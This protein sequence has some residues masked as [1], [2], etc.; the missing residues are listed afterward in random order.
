MFWRKGKQTITPIKVDK[1][2]RKEILLA[3]LYLFSEH[4]KEEKIH[5]YK[6]VECISEVQKDLLPLGYEFSEKFLYS[7]DLFAD[8]DALRYEGY[9]RQYKSR[10]SDILPKNFVVLKPLGRVKA[11]KIIENLSPEI[12]EG[13]NRAITITLNRD[14]VLR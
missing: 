2:R 11:K 6:F 10:Q 5:R 1:S 14:E 12:L 4:G 13:L 8:L 3:T 9:I 7:I